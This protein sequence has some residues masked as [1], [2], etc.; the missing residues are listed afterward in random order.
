MADLIAELLLMNLVRVAWS[1]KKL[2]I[3]FYSALDGIMAD[4]ENF[5]FIKI[6]CFYFRKIL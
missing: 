1:C 4:R 3:L 6:K 5:I 2:N